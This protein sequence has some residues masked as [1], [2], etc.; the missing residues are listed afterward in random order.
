[1]CLVDGLML[2]HTR[3]STGLPW[4]SPRITHPRVPPE[5]QDQ[6]PLLHKV[7]LQALVLGTGAGGWPRLQHQISQLR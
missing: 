1:V 7:A 4:Y 2:Q 3:L 6:L 5:S